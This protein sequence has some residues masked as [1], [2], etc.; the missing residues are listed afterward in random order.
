MLKTRIFEKVRKLSCEEKVLAFF[1]HIIECD[2]PRRTN[3]KGL[4]GV[5]ANA[6][7]VIRSIL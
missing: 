1:S 2:K 5:L 7:E 4:Q 3:Y 6:G